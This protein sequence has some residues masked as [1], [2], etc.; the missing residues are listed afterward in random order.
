MLADA[1]GCPKASGKGAVIKIVP[2]RLASKVISVTETFFKERGE[3][4]M[5]QNCGGLLAKDETYGFLVT[6]LVIGR[7]A[8]RKNAT[9]LG[10]KL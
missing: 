8:P 2:M 1:E 9:A 5:R 7:R 10:E 3:K 4:W 6:D